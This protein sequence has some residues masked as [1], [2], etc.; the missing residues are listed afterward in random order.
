MSILLKIYIIFQVLKT[1]IR[2]N[3]YARKGV[4]TNKV[5]YLYGTLKINRSVTVHNC[6]FMIK[7]HLSIALQI[8]KNIAVTLSHCDIF[9][10]GYKV[11][12]GVL[13]A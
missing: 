5:F 3:W 1:T 6:T 4:V 10:N 2:F 8:K 13:I 9:A 12:T 11:D 7:T